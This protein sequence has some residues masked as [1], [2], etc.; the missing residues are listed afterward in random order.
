MANSVVFNGKEFKSATA[1]KNN[2]RVITMEAVIK[3]LAE[4]FGEENIAKV[5]SNEYG[6]IVGTVLDKDG[7]ASD[8]V[9]T[10]KPT[11]K[12][13]ESRRTEKRVYEQYI[14][15]DEAEAYRMAVEEKEEEKRKKEEEKKKKIEA[16]KKRKEEE[17]KRKEAEQKA[18]AEQETEGEIE[19]D[20]EEIEEE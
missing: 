14:L 18:E 16:D 3:G 19:G 8:V 7:F 15:E 12:E 1:V 5:G 4:A 17:K 10:V 2:A 13:W 11:V 20:I 9:V 6:V